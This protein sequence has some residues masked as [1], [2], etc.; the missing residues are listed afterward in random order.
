M[1]L[2][3]PQVGHYVTYNGPV[4]ANAELRKN[5]YEAAYTAEQA[6]QKVK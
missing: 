2:Q 4:P 1:I 5:V 6:K 3:N